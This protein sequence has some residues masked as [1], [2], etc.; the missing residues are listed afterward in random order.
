MTSRDISEHPLV[1]VSAAH[2][3]V[4]VQRARDA[5]RRCLEGRGHRSDVL[6]RG[7]FTMLWQGLASL[8]P[9]S[10]EAIGESEA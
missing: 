10:D 3:D 8:A 9:A 6:P 4:I 1:G 5:L 7:A 2:V